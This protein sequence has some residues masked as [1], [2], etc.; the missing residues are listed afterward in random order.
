MISLLTLVLA[1]TTATGTAA[2]SATA[3]PTSLEDV[4]VIEGWLGRRISPRWSFEAQRAYKRGKCTSAVPY[5]G[6]NLLEVDVLFLLAPDGK[7]LKIIPVNSHCPEID[8]YVGTKIQTALKSSFPKH[9]AS[10]DPRW[11][12]SQV[13]FLW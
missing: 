8:A 4:P 12:R 11:M 7:P 9:G 3:I 10:A 13:R 5:E 6:A 1:A 2:T